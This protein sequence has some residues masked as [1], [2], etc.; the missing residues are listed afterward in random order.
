MII[1]IEGTDASGKATLCATLAKALQAKHPT[2][3]VMQQSFP[4][5]STDSGSAILRVLK[6]EILAGDKDRALILQALMAANRYEVFQLLAEF[7]VSEDRILILDRYYISGL[8]YGFA[9]GLPSGWLEALHDALPP[10]EISILLDL[11]VEEG[12]RRRPERRDKYEG[13]VTFL[14]SVRKLYVE[15]FQNAHSRE[16][17]LEPRSFYI[18]DASQPPHAVL[19][20]AL[21]CVENHRTK[22]H[23]S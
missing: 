17:G 14:E 15:Y 23:R 10:A 9:D 1:T 3:L 11:S 16:L 19:N 5:Y 6:G 18:I 20:E 4:D 8:V 22:G 21:R 7:E 12:F 2:H 13:D